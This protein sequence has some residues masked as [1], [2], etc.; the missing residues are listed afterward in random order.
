MPKAPAHKRRSGEHARGAARING[1][2]LGLPDTASAE[3]ADKYPDGATTDTVLEPVDRLGDKEM[4]EGKPSVAEVG[5][6]LKRKRTARGGAGWT[7]G[8]HPVTHQRR[9]AREK[10]VR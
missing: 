8:K 1:L 9:A 2:A 6:T 10:E 4:D 3:W 5:T 7:G